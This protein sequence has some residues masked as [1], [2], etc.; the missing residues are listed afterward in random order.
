MAW[1]R[2]PA[3]MA[4]RA[5][6]A[7]IHGGGGGWGRGATHMR[8]P[9]KHEGGAGWDEGGSE[10]VGRR[11]QLGAPW[12]AMAV[13]SSGGGSDRGNGSEGASRAGEGDVTL[14]WWQGGAE[15]R[16]HRW[17]SSIGSVHGGSA[18]MSKESEVQ[19]V[20]EDEEGALRLLHHGCRTQGTWRGRGRFARAW[21]T[22][23][24]RV[25]PVEDLHRAAGR[26][27]SGP[28]GM[29]FWATSGPIWTMGPK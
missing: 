5:P 11:R 29:C 13:T 25:A 9:T 7:T 28:I 3:A 26:C 15:A 24:G 27:R 6:M 2:V 8:W 19:G 23:S 21:R 10:V 14:D 12:T 17:Q 4:E 18:L 22:H 16:K 20:E 1:P